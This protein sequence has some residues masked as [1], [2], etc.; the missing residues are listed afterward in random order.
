MDS[1][2]DLLYL[3][4]TSRKE[5]RPSNWVNRESLILGLDTR[6]E[7]GVRKSKDIG[8]PSTLHIKGKTSD[9]SYNLEWRGIARPHGPAG[10]EL[11]EQMLS[12]TPLPSSLQSSTVLSIS[13]TQLEVRGQDAWFSSYRLTSLGHRIG[14]RKVENRPGE[15]N[16]IFTCDLTLVHQFFSL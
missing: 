12:I 15:A 3:S 2:V 4:G 10:R 14:S 1:A 9:R 6:D 16:T 8:S 13:W 5:K 11:G 7:Q